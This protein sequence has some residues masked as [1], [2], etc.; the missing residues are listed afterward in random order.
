VAYID[1]NYDPL[2]ESGHMRLIDVDTEVARGVW[3]RQ[4]PGHTRDM[5]IVTAE[6]G[7][8]TFC[9][10]SDLIPTAAHVTPTWVTAFDLYPLESVDSKLRWLREAVRGGW[11]CAFGHDPEIA[12]TRIAQAGEKFEVLPYFTGK[13]VVSR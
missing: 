8:E 13:E 6:S 1:A 9:F 4:A 2:V 11:V 10:F 12:F 5:M 3:L 7:G